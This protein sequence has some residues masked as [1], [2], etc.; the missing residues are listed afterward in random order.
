MAI[1][2]SW[3]HGN[4][5]TIQDPVYKHPDGR[6]IG[7]YR[8]TPCGWGMQATI[9]GSRASS[10]FHLPIPTVIPPLSTFERFELRRLFLLFSCQNGSVD[11]VHI[12]DGLELV[13][14]FNIH[15]AE[16]SYLSKGQFQNTFPLSSPHLVH[17]GI[18]LSFL[19]IPHSQ[20]AGDIDLLVSAGG[21][22][23][24]IR[25]LLFSTLVKAF[26]RR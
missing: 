23:F 1:S 9:D 19:F 17:T 22:E 26:L 3:T 18:S 8:L 24:E 7:R 20:P 10:W 4:A 25:S 12:Y 6:E 16:G 5:L 14:Q 13:E 21:A 2:T 11:N 15:S